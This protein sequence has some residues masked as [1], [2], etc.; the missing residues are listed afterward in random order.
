[1]SIDAGEVSKSDPFS[2]VDRRILVT[3]GTRGIGRAVVLEFARAGAT[4][5][6]NYVRDQNA[7]GELTELAARENLAIQVCRADIS[8]DPGVKALVEFATQGGTQLSAFV[9]CAATGVHKPVAQLTPRHFDWTYSLNVRA[10]LA[11][12]VQLLPSFRPGSSIVAVSSEGATR[13]VPQ[14]T[15][16]G[17]SKG[18]L[19]SMVRH[20]AAEL[21]S[22]G[23]R[24][25]AIAPGS[26]MTDA[27]KVLPD[28]ERRLA[29][30]VA[31]TP[32]GRL[33]SLEEVARTARFLCS[34]AAS[35]VVG[36][37]LVV[38]GGARIVA[39]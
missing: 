24:V 39:S 1:M 12:V 34:E 15:L 10:F 36:Q 8:G 29:E 31:R 32:L 26:V 13:A 11:L 14:Y 17:S 21:A 37:T 7:A 5:I 20:F 2:L 33:V 25:N 38:D 6:A 19:E 16:V 22:Q 3:G 35:G 4:V 30:T 18:A 23:I 9:H 28:A 27:W